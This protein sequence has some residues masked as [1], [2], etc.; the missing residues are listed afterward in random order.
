MNSTR[1]HADQRRD[2]LANREDKALAENRDHAEAFCKLG[3]ALIG[4]KSYSEALAAYD[5]AVAIKP[6][7]ADAFN[8]R[9]IALLQLNRP[10][11][12]LESFEKALAAKSDHVQALYNHGNVLCDL[13]R[14][15]EALASY[16]QAIAAKPDY[17]DAFNNRGN[18]LQD[19]KRPLEAIASYD[20]ALAIRPTYVESH[21]NRGILLGELG[22]LALAQEALETAIKLAPQR[23]RSHFHLTLL[24]RTSPG[25]PHLA[26]MENLALRIDSLAP[27]EQIDL[28][29]ALAKACEDSG[30]TEQSFRRLVAGNALKRKAVVYHEDATLR[31]FKR[32]IKTFTADSMRLGPE[33]GEPSDAPVFIFGMP[34]SGSTLVEQILASH[35]RVVALG[36]VDDFENALMGLRDSAGNALQFPEMFAAPSAELLR[37]LGASYLRSVGA[38]DSAA[39]RITDKRPGNFL[40]AGL[41]H[42]ALPKARMIHTRRN[43]VDTCWSCFSQRFADSGSLPCAY[44]LGELGRYYRAYEALMAHWRGVL[45]QNV[46]LEVQYE[47]VVEDIEAQ[48]RRI[49]AHCGLEWDPRCL[50]FHRTERQVRTVSVAQ[51]RQPLYKSAVGRW[52]RFEPFLEPLLRELTGGVSATA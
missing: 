23:A 3:N 14:P 25:D 13:K 41:I 8:N 20:R 45:P 49:L 12:A 37:R 22:Q 35:P 2:P 31:V 42:L 36:E 34:R 11:L 5:K 10:R 39:H 16:D 4:L 7:Y 21:E 1:P 30:D 27:S 15:T 29:F 6:D 43:P 33:G 24:R 19:L 26:V 40:Y 52:R 51:V 47:D 48:T 9:G 44:D 18:A 32:L 28:N 46:M 50:A 38:A 17:A